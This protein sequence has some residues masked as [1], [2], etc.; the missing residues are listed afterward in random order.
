MYLNGFEDL[1]E[2]YSP[3]PDACFY[4]S[5]MLQVG[6]LLI[7]RPDL[8]N[9]TITS[10]DND[11]TDTTRTYK[12]S[13]STN[14]VKINSLL[15]R[16]SIRLFAALNDTKTKREENDLEALISDVFESAIHL[17]SNDW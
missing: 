10:S 6:S 14:R 1:K 4:V 7:N 16:S 5:S 15:L 17:S 3:Y 11:T 12:T 9:K 8:S 13:D 2:P